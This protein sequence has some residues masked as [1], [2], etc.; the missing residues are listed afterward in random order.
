M[1][2]FKPAYQMALKWSAHPKAPH[3][4][5]FLSFIEAFIFPV[6]PETMLAPMTLSRREL[7]VRF[8]TISLI[9]SIFG[10]LIGYG[11]GYFAIEWMEPLLRYFGW[12]ER[13]LQAKQ[14]MEEKGFWM[15]LIG[16]FAPIP[17]KFLTWASG[18]VAMPIW[19]FLAGMIIGRGKRV[20]LLAG[21]IFWKGEKAEAWLQRWIEWIGWIALLCLGALIVGFKFLS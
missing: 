9:F 13:F 17:L 20:F 2:I 10:S 21:V 16:G 6:P 15:L 18:A 4:L 5:G 7:W 12:S 1:R 19:P 14:L 8:A 11:I 3:Y